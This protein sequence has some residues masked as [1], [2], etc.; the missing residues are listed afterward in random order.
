MNFCIAGEYSNA[1]IKFWVS[2][3]TF[4]VEWVVK[5]CKRNIIPE[6]KSEKK[7]LRYRFPGTILSPVTGLPNP[8]TPFMPPSSFYPS[9]FVHWRNGPIPGYINVF[10]RL[11]YIL[12]RNPDMAWA[13]SFGPGYN[14]R[15]ARAVPHHHLAVGMR[16]I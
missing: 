14:L 1:N 8:S 11:P 3:F 9:P 6:K 13:R 4:P 2:H 16:C 5:Y 15:C 12:A 10:M 7:S